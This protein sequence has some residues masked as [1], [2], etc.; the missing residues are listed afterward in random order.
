MFVYI[1]VVI[2]P[3]LVERLYKKTVQAQGAL[4]KDE[5]REK[6]N[7]WRYILLAA[8][9]MFFLIAF[10]NQSIG[11]DTNGYLENFQKTKTLV[12]KLDQ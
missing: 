10:R 2:F 6:K 9:P 5:A 1:L 8:L 7:R 3:L 4:Q 11:A 12:T